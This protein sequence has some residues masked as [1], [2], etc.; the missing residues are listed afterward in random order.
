MT[1]HLLWDTTFTRR[2][3]VKFSKIRA[4]P[5]L[6]DCAVCWQEE[7]PGVTCSTLWPRGA[8]I[9]LAWSHSWPSFQ[10]EV[11]LE[12]F[13]GPCQP[14]V[15]YDHKKGRCFQCCRSKGKSSKIIASLTWE[16]DFLISN[17]C[18][19]RQTLS[20]CTNSLMESVMY[21][22][23]KQLSPHLCRWMPGAWVLCVLLQYYEC[24]KQVNNNSI[25]S[26]VHPQAEDS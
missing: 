14:E 17:I 26:P 24:Y 25:Q 8:E 23:E 19:Y 1:P 18:P 20:I 4:F 13:W 22:K 5:S 9:I 2:P 11:G 3:D 16:N 7:I 12:T 21:V 15:T 6:R 10:Q